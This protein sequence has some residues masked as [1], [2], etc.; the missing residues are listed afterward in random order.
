MK[1]TFLRINE[2]LANGLNQAPA[3]AI[4]STTET[5]NVATLKQEEPLKPKELHALLILKQNQRGLLIG[6][7]YKE[8][9]G[10]KPSTRKQV[11]NLKATILAR[12]FQIEKKCL[13][14][15]KC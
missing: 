9:N 2:I 4:A 12:L 8:L 6:E 7:L 3:T 14:I 15:S 11:I 5:K 10:V 1:V 13:C